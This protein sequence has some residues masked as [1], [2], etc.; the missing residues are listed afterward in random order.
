MQPRQVPPR[1]LADILLERRVLVEAH[2][3]ETSHDAAGAP[4]AHYHVTVGQGFQMT[5]EMLEVASLVVRSLDVNFEADASGMSVESLSWIFQLTGLT[6]LRMDRYPYEELSDD[7]GNL[8]ELRHLYMYGSALKK[9]P[10]T[11]GSLS[12]LVRLNL[13]TSYGLHYLPIEVLACT[14]LV[15]STFSTRAL[16]NNYKNRLGLPQLPHWELA[17]PNSGAI[18]GCVEATLRRCHEGKLLVVL[19]QRILTFLPWNWC[20]MCGR[21]FLHD[22]ACFAWSHCV[23]G[24]DAQSLL[25]LCCSRACASKVADQVRYCSMSRAN[26]RLVR[27]T[28]VHEGPS[29]HMGSMSSF[30]T[31]F[32]KDHLTAHPRPGVC[33]RFQPVP[34][35]KHNLP[36][37]ILADPIVTDIGTEVHPPCEYRVVE[38]GDV[39]SMP[40]GLKLGRLSVGDLLRVTRTYTADCGRVWLLFH[41]TRE[42]CDAKLEGWT[43]LTKKNGKRKLQKE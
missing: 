42:V 7:I 2:G 41:H 22:F 9:V 30:Y 5:P 12:N 24:S 16:F 10:R 20:S 1:Q 35:E 8:T 26:K 33:K 28:W 19:V 36:M 27:G 39:R 32:S 15:D 43:A 17:P 18:P 21:W 37:E 11:I 34:V 3:M 4:P 6:E 25:A 40:G 23:V 38:A 29:R 31:S 14:K 13:Y